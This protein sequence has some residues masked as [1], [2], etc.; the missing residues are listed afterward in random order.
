M[1]L[2]IEK[3]V[4]RP[5]VR[6]SVSQC[7]PQIAIAYVELV[8]RSNQVRQMHGLLQRWR[9]RIKRPYQVPGVSSFGSINIAD[10]TI[11]GSSVVNDGCMQITLKIL[12]FNLHTCD[13]RNSQ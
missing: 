5:L 1:S 12:K 6:H 9:Q 4:S 8:S 3:T 11:K 2:G 13:C 7:M 10:I